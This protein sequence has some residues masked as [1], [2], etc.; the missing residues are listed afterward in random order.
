[1]LSSLLSKFTDPTFLQALC[2]GLFIAAILL[3]FGCIAYHE[4]RSKKS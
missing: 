3:V 4:L 1:M 2:A